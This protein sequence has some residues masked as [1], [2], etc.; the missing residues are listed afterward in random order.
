MEG[1]M[2]RDINL[3]CKICALVAATAL[4]LISAQTSAQ[5]RAPQGNDLPGQSMKK[6]PKWIPTHSSRNGEEVK[7]PKDNP[8]SSPFANPSKNARP[9]KKLTDKQH[10]KFYQHVDLSDIRDLAVYSGGRAMILDTLARE[11]L[12]KIYGR[13]QIGRAHV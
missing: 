12:E 5:V 3:L 9:A 11:T 7:K 10:W 4:L 1:S 13:S 2:Y 8:G 6:P